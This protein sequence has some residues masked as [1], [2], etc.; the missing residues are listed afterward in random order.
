MD[1][2]SLRWKRKRERILRRDKYM[3]QDAKRYGRAEEATTVHHIY[4]AAEYPEYRWATWNLTSLSAENHGKMHDKTTGILTEK[5][6][7]WQ[8]RTVPP[9]KKKNTPPGCDFQ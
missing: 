2:K 7:E 1:Y 8:R 9:D 6:M 4:P 5:G 3:C